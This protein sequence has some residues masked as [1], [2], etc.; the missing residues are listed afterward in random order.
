MIFYFLAEFRDT[1]MMQRVNIWCARK[2]ATKFQ[3]FTYAF[4]MA[5]ISPNFQGM[6]SDY[7]KRSVKTW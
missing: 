1:R 3:F 2:T 5:E 7:F 6:F 4:L